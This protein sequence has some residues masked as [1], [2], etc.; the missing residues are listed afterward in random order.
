[1]QPQCLVQLAHELWRHPAYLVTDSFERDRADL[2]C[3]RLRVLPQ[4]SV[5]RRKENLKRI[6]LPRVRGNRDHGEHT[7]PK[8][9]SGGIST[10]IA[11]D[12]GETPLV[13]FGAA[14][15]LEVNQPDVAPAHQEPSPS[16][17]AESHSSAS[18]L[19]SHSCHASA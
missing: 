12:D 16:P 9:R 15:R 14:S 3:L 8:A 6:D 2:F 7:P 5:C 11:D 13:R 4:A 17:E 10:V 18:P 1:M 19:S